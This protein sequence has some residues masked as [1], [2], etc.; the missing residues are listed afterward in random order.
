MNRRLLEAFEDALVLGFRRFGSVLSSCLAVGD[1]G[2]HRW[3]YPAFECLVNCRGAISG[4]ADIRRPI[5]HVAQH[6]VSVRRSRPGIIGYFLRQ[7]G[8]RGRET[9]EV[10]ELACR[11]TFM[12][13]IN[14]I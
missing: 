4:I 14:V 8:Y 7:V 6:L 3:N 11:E 2:K 13:G 12:E 10:I 5:Q 1:R 9:G